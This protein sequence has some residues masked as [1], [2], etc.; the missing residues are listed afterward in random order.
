L[1]KFSLSIGQQLEKSNPA[2]GLFQPKS[3]FR[4]LSLRGKRSNLAFFHEIATHLAGAHND[5]KGK[6]FHSLNRDLGSICQLKNK[7]ESVKNR[8]HHYSNLKIIQGRKNDDPF[9]QKWLD[10][11]PVFNTFFNRPPKPNAFQDNQNPQ[12]AKD[13]TES[14]DYF[15]GRNVSNLPDHLRRPSV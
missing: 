5:R 9:S 10:D 2:E 6:G 13:F 8:I 7:I 3:R 14:K 15:K 11:H 12:D 1:R 4:K